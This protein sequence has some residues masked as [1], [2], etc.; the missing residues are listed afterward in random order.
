MI[1]MKKEIDRGK[2]MRTKC[3]FKKVTGWKLS[4]E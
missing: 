3:Q 2:K 4:Y 1:T